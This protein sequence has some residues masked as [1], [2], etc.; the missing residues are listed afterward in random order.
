MPG[1]IVRT[2]SRALVM[3]KNGALIVPALA[4]LPAGDT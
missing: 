1:L 4:S 2:T 3:V